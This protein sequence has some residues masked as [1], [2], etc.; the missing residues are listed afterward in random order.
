MKKIIWM[1]F[2]LTIIAITAQ[3]VCAIDKYSI[4]VYD[5]D[6]YLV[7]DAI[8]TVRDGDNTVATGTTN[9]GGIFEAWLNS[10]IRYQITATLGNQFGKWEGYP[11]NSKFDIY[12]NMR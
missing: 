8:V 1:V 6:N 5:K 10:G 12:I 11:S 2:A 9:S 3:S 7:K 4:Y